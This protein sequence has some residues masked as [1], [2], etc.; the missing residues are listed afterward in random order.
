MR[1]LVF[2]VN[3]AE[4]IGLLPGFGW[5]AGHNPLVTLVIFSLISPGA[6]FV[7]AK[8]GESRPLPTS[9]EQQFR[10]F[11]PGDLFLAMSATILVAMA[12][13][14]PA[15]ARWYNA[16][17]WHVIVLVCAVAVAIL[18]TVGEYNDPNG[19]GHRAVLSPTKLYHNI[20]LYGAYGYVIVVTL[21]AL[22]AGLVIDWQWSRAALLLFALIPGFIWVGLLKADSDA[23]Y[24]VKESRKD[25]AHVNDWEPI[26][27]RSHP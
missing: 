1:K 25:Y 10:S 20:L 4:K 9:Y 15:Q 26:W 11:F 23:P 24:E 27:S 22:I 8:I 16:R 12:V 13:L 14:L 21:V 17:L 5:L 19:Y 3:D 7:L 2:R 6:M 18:I